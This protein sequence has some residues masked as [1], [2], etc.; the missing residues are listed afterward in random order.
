MVST[1]PPK[2]LIAGLGALGLFLLLTSI[3]GPF[4]IDECHYLVT[5]TGLSQGRLTVPGTEGLKPNPE[6]FYF[7][8]VAKA[9][10]SWQTPAA[11]TAPA[12][13]APL[14]LPFSYFGWRGLVALNILAFIGCALLVYHYAAR[15]ASRP[16][17]PVL[18]TVA[19]LFGSYCLEYAQGIW[20][21]MLS[22]FL[23]MGCLVLSDRARAG[24]RWPWASL[25]GI[26]GGLATGIRY[27]N[28]I[29][30]GFTGV[31]VLLWAPDR[32]PSAAHYGLGVAGPLL[33]SA[34]FNRYRNGWWNPVSK[35]SYYLKS[36]GRQ[37]RGARARQP[38]RVLWAKLFDYTHH[39]PVQ[40]L[41][42]E[43]GSGAYLLQRTLKRALV[44]STPW[45]LVSFM[46]MGLSWRRNPDPPAGASELRA[47][48]LLI[49][50]LLL[51]FGMAGWRRTD[52]FCFNQRYF[53][54]MLPM[55]A[56]GMAWASER[57]R[58]PVPQLV[59][60]LMAGA[61][62]VLSFYL[63]DYR[64]PVRHVGLLYTPLVLAAAT[65]I[66]WFMAR[67]KPRW[68]YALLLGAC[69]SWAATVHLGEDLPGSRRVR[70]RKTWVAR[71]AERVIEGGGPAAV[72][73]HFP[74]SIN[75]CR[76]HLDHDVVVVDTNLDAGIRGRR[77]VDELL[78]AGR[79]VYL[80]MDKFYP[81]NLKKKMLRDR[82]HRTARSVAGLTIEEIVK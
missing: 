44:Q 81:E 60:G 34:L 23:C 36:L 57:A 18:A 53:I 78:A 80:V 31:G 79:R 41:S 45:A 2:W 26:S 52:G 63:L 16:E 67:R 27:Q 14:A 32:I 55:L 73:A 58:L 74:L 20:P 64:N 48:T 5:V 38:F 19:F 61:V 37:A 28:L 7:D 65:V 13:Y 29:Y 21:H 59:A 42:R 68:I 8:P 11:A 66:A 6:L 72:V 71:Q 51:V 12:L 49:V 43:P 56:V 75:F 69:I 76:L 3:P 47:M 54:D 46:A 30:A 22:M 4:L 15:H 62:A 50:P 17:T 9:K 39:P 77:V 82:T 24:K 40:F 10:D 70:N 35:G 33:A 1:R 25:S